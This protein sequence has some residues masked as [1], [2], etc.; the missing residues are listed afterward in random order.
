MNDD[1]QNLQDLFAGLALLGLLPSAVK[2]GKDKD[3]LASLAYDLAG[4]MIR[5]RNA[6]KEVHDERQ[7]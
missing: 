4:A 3:Q 5:E 6:R 2:F 1:E 7:A